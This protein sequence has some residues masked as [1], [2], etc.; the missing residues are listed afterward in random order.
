MMKNNQENQI[1]LGGGCFWCLEA[2]FHLVK[3]VTNL[4]VGYSDGNI[5]QPTYEQ[6]CQGN[7]GYIEVIKLT[8]NPTI[9]SLD[10][11][12]TIFFTLHDP[13]SLARQGNDVGY[14]Y[15]S[16]VFYTKND[17][18]NIIDKVVLKVSR[19]YIKPI[20]TIIKPLKNFYVAE[21]EHQDYFT[22]HPNQAYC[23]IIINPK[24]TKLRQYY[25]RYLASD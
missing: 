4:I 13:T 1:V 9:I 16:A 10:S 21:E 3:G 25:S 2:T 18:K 23:Q 5:D 12:L 6:V 17:Q 19:L 15:S 22:K 8:F 11:I 24:I 7:T 14:Q 20:V